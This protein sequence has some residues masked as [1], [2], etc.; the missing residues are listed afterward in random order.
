MGQVVLVSGLM[1]VVVAW[2]VG[3]SMPCDCGRDGYDLITLE[4]SLTELKVLQP[5]K[6]HIVIVPDGAVSYA[7]VM[8]A[9]R[10]HFPLQTVQL[11]D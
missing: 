7:D 8:D 9:V 1:W 4:A 3:R 10:P 2:W 6:Q 11:H 5:E